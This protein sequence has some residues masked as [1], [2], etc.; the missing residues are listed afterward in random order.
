[1][2]RYKLTRPLYWLELGLNHRL[3]SQEISDDLIMHYH[4]H[5]RQLRL[6]HRQRLEFRDYA[7][8]QGHLPSYYCQR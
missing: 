1:M 5:R 2:Q 7:F 8:Q 4:L 6:R 3:G